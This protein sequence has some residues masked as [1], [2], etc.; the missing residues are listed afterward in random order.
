VLRAGGG[1]SSLTIVRPAGGGGVGSLVLTPVRR[2]DCWRVE[3]AWPSH[4]RR[5]FG[6]FDSQ[7]EAE[8]WIKAHDWLTKQSQ[9]RDAEQPTDQGQGAGDSG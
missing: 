8:K 4:P 6:N 3:L 5:Y 7:A 1:L 9:E 2:S